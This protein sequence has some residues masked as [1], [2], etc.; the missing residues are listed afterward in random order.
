MK[1]LEDLSY[2]HARFAGVGGVSETE[3]AKLEISMCFLMDFGLRVDNELLYAKNKSLLTFVASRALAPIPHMRLTVP[4]R[5][6]QVVEA[7]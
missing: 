6:R 5:L 3:L 1:A 2:P 4:E 7:S